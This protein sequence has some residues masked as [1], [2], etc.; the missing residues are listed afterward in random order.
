MKKCIIYS[1]DCLNPK[2]DVAIVADMSESVDN[3]NSVGILKE[4]IS[5]LIQ[6]SSVDSGDIRIAL[7]MFTHIVYNDFYLNTYTNRSD[8]IHH[9]TAIGRRQGATSTG[10]AIQNLRNNVF[11]SSKGDR[12][13]A[14]NVAVVITDGKSDN[15][16]LTLSQ[17]L[18]AK[19]EGIHMIVVAIGLTDQTEIN[20]IASDPF[21]ENV[22]TV[23]DFD[24]LSSLEG[25]IERIYY[26]ECH[27]KL[28]TLVEMYVSVHYFL[29]L[30]YVIYLNYITDCIK[31]FLT[32]NGD[33]SVHM[34][35]IHMV[36]NYNI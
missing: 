9:I 15:T 12:D 26:P 30:F 14:P 7:S 21:E 17:S 6:K 31:V 8:M 20:D 5:V 36:I 24:Q 16:S 19:S 11:V 28:T 32:L 33:Y 3:A 13:D 2:Y 34:Y 27:C 4:F 25:L 35:M 10:L 23:D 29:L 1:S 22:F 18:L